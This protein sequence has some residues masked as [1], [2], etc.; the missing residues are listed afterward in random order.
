M[1]NETDQ[2]YNMTLE[3]VIEA[4]IIKVQTCAHKIKE[5]AG[6]LRHEGF[7]GP[8]MGEL[9]RLAENLLKNVH[10]YQA[11]NNINNSQ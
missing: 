2:G 7:E 1:R 6:V 10:E 8:E 3:P 11:Y 9:R 4:T 5:L